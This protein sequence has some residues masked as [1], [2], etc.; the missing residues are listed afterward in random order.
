MVDTTKP[1]Y[2][3]E[4]LLAWYEDK[5]YTNTKDID[6]SMRVAIYVADFLISFYRLLADKFYHLMSSG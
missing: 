3:F 2:A 6:N 5:A 1:K 4:E